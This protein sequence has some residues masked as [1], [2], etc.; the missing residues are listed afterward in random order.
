[1]W[2]N[3]KKFF[4]GSYHDMRDQQWL[5]TRKAGFHQNNAAVNISTELDN[6]EMTETVDGEIVVRLTLANRDLES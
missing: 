2:K 3:F 6:L 1:M 4:Y 5:M